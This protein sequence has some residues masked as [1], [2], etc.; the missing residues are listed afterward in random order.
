MICMNV[1]IAIVA[2]TMLQYTIMGWLGVMGPQVAMAAIISMN[3]MIATWLLQ[4]V[5]VPV[6]TV[7]VMIVTA[8][9]TMAPGT[10]AVRVA[11]TEAVMVRAIG[12]LCERATH[13]S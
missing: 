10:E 4:A 6:I 1:A 3:V 13:L 11:A 5:T 2:M 7:S 12:D 9:M 8:A